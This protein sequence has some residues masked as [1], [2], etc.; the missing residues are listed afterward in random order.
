MT[1]FDRQLA[2]AD[3]VEAREVQLQKEYD[4]AFAWGQKLRALIN[5]AKANKITNA[6]LPAVWGEA[7]TWESIIGALEDVLTD[8]GCEALDV[9]AQ[10]ELS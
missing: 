10:N 5:E 9:L 1:A 7:D 8:T 2:Y 6:P 4:R 3:A